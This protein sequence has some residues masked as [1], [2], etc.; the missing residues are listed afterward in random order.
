[1]GS[2][3][4]PLINMSIRANIALGIA[5]GLFFLI[6]LRLFYLQ[7][8]KGDHYRVRSENNRLRTVFVPPPR[9]IIYDRNGQPLVR[10]RPAFN[11]EFVAED[12]VSPKET[13]QRVS[14]LLE[15]DP[16]TLKA[17][18]AANTR[19]RRFEPK[20]LLKDVSRDIVA[21]VEAHRYMIP[22]VIINVDPARDYIHKD[23]AA[24][25]LGYVREITPAQMEQPAFSGYRFGD[26]V[27]QYGL[28]LRWERFLQGQRGIQNVIVD[29][30]GN[31]IGESSF[32][33][34]KPGN[35]LTLTLDLAVQMAADRALEKR[36]GAIV[37]MDPRTGEILALASAP[38]FDPN[39]FAGEIPPDVWRA[40]S[41]GEDKPLSDRAIQG[42]FPPGSVFKILMSIAAI[43][44]GVIDPHER[45]FCPGYYS[46]GGRN[47]RCHK[48]S[49]HGSVDHYD[50]LVQSCDVYYYVVGNRLGVD[51][52]HEYATKFGLGQSTGL[53]LAHEVPGLIPST[54]WRRASS[55][56]PE[57]Q[58]WYPGETLSVVIG[59]GAVS[60]T[61][62]QMARALAAV[63]NGGKVVKPFLVRQVTA[64]DGRVI[65]QHLTSPEQRDVEIPA[66]VLDQVRTAMVGVVNDPK[67]TG[68]GAKLR[69]DL[70]F[71]VG[72]KTGTAQVVA[73][74]RA[75]QRGTFADHAWFAGYAP[76][77]DPQ[78]VIA[79]LV[80]NGGSGG[81]T[82]APLVRSVLEAYFE[83]R[84]PKQ[85]IE[86]TSVS[87]ATEP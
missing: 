80:E 53:G 9:G 87:G 54:A 27:G 65:E 35:N 37:A 83:A 46:F 76:A 8:L 11:V 20:V 17:R 25:V 7:I 45:V 42:A 57:R 70:G 23:L 40:L 36:R 5:A 84:N 10:N 26:T 67:G 39:L 49:G 14:D 55:T 24:H 4:R 68:R 16:A 30:M 12:A 66:N 47:Y 50:A 85:T 19:R 31:R 64:V 78:I 6:A 56:N 62:L 60:T 75:S 51:R 81:A 34:E 61:P 79:A 3:D 69:G 29:A 21:R 13:L 52:I 32:Q 86:S 73:L 41:T 48:K 59:Q 44:E 2:T 71:K 58:K 28:E 33:E 1:M 82:A 72:G 18:L 63:V 22:G 43:T 15:I 77:E 38:R 74:E